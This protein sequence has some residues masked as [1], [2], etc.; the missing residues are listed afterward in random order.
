MGRGQNGPQAKCRLLL[1]SPTRAMQ[2]KDAL[3]RVAVWAEVVKEEGT[4]GNRGCAYGISFDCAVADQ[5]RALLRNEGI[6]VSQYLQ[7][8]G[9]L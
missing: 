7:R 9:R 4:R 8:E 6:A 5:V 2:A 3:S 1:E